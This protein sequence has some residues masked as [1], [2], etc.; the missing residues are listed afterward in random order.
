MKK[1]LSQF[2][3]TAII[4]TTV[5]LVNNL[6]FAWTSPGQDPPGGNVF[7]PLNVGSDAQY[8]DGPLGVGG[9]FRAYGG[10]QFDNF[11]DC[12]LTTDGTGLLQCGTGGGEGEIVNV[13]T[14]DCR[15][16]EDTTSGES[17]FAYCNADEVAVGGGTWRHSWGTFIGTLPTP[18]SKAGGSA[19]GWAG[20]VEGGG[21]R[22]FTAVK[23]CKVETI[24]TGGG[25]G[26]GTGGSG[27]IAFNDITQASDV[28]TDNID[29][30]ESGV[31][32]VSGFLYQQSTINN[33]NGFI[34][35]EVRVDGNV[36]CKDVAHRYNLNNG[37]Q[38]H[39][40]CT[41]VKELAAGTHTVS[42]TRYAESSSGFVYGSNTLQY[43]VYGNGN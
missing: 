43:V 16:V 18:T 1:T 7:A 11:T 24:T 33:N 27:V 28:I 2:L 8:K 38:L 13:I 15:I 14:D 23:C 3:Y 17:A 36:C 25:G 40:S 10:I 34:R 35:T 21:D 20:R 42:T 31:I 26:A 41:C 39:A 30:A 5:F 6:I 9:A 37:E 19:N 22:A 29:I 4:L 32:T 12:T